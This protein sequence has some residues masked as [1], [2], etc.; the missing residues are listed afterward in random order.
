VKAVYENCREVGV[1]TFTNMLINTPGETEKDLQDIIALLD[2]IKS[3]IVSINVFTPYPGT[4]IAAEA[5]GELAREE[6]PLLMKDP[7]K[8]AIEMPE[9]FRFA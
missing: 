4:A 6:Y 9:K 3:D 5:V 7:G 8:L 1:R 2:E